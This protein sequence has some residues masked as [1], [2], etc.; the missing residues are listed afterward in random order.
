M[1]SSLLRFLWQ[2]HNLCGS[3]TAKEKGLVEVAGFYPLQAAVAH[4]LVP[5]QGLD[6]LRLVEALRNDRQEV[7]QRDDPDHVPL[8]GN[9]RQMTEPFVEHRLGGVLQARMRRDRHRV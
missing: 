8:V 7:S 9:D 5:G 3:Q 1:D 6:R 2:I 4:E